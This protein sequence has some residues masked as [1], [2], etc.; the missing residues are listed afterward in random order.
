MRTDLYCSVIDGRPQ[1]KHAPA[2]KKSYINKK[3]NQS[4]TEMFG[5]KIIIS[6]ILA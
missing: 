6:Y 4:R 1:L 2:A 3:L 5:F